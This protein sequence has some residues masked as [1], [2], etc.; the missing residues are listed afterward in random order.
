VDLARKEWR[1]GDR[2]QPLPNGVDLARFRPAPVQPVAAGDGA[3]P[4]TI[5]T[6]GGLRGEKDHAVLLQALAAMRRP[7]RLLLVGDGPERGALEARARDLGIAARVQFAG[8]CADSAPHHRAT[9]PFAPASR[10][11]QMP[12][13]LLEAMASGLRVASTDV[14]DVRAML[15][16]ACRG[17]LA[18]PGDAAALARVMDDLAADPQRRAREGAANR[19]RCEQRY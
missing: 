3:R 5:G 14:G 10:T 11:A 2:G 19:R 1:L 8:S 13:S 12:I 17:A 16:P 9:G 7:A 15:P 4:F 6:V 18:P